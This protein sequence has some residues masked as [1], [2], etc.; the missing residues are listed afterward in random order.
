[1][2]VTVLTGFLGA[3]KTTLLNHLLHARSDRRMAVIENEFSEVSIDNELVVTT[4]ANLFELS[5][6][7]LCCTVRGDLIRILAEVSQRQPAYDHLVIEASGLAN[8]G[9]VAQTFFI[10]E[11]L[12][13]QAELS[14]VVTVVDAKH[15]MHQLAESRACL[16]QIAFADVLIINKCDLVDEAELDRI[17]HRIRVIN[18]AARVER[19]TFGRVQADAILDSSSFALERALFARPDFLVKEPPFEHVS[20]FSLARGAHQFV[21]RADPGDATRVIVVPEK[22]LPEME[23]DVLKLAVD[24]DALALEP[25]EAVPAGRWVQLAMGEETSPRRYTFDA[26]RAG[27]YALFSQYRP[28]A[29]GLDLADLT[30]TPHTPVTEHDY[31][32]G[33]V[34]EAGVGSIAISSS[35]PV[36]VARLTA[37]LTELLETRHETLYRIKGILSVPGSDVRQIIHA[38]HEVV[39]LS[40]GRPWTADGRRLSQLV[41]I[42]RDL[43]RKA[44]QSGFRACLLAGAGGSASRTWTSS[45]ERPVVPPS[46]YKK[47]L[48]F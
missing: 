22:P 19:V 28:S 41:F 16:D 25:G 33:H 26:P 23:R 8:P 1:M 10:D 36:D 21:L 42:G 31:A 27:R 29:L 18:S 30:G 2:P 43:D 3:G 13:R 17:E 24:Q 40:T 38:V 11:T 5:R 7:C 9:A 39:D 44:L 48:R 45:S 35:R 20:V 47:R 37:W 46:R 4:S 32:A 12:K 15:V 34:H 6:G 14:A